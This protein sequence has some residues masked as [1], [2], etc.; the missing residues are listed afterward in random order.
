MSIRYLVR[1]PNPEDLSEIRS[2]VSDLDNLLGAPG[3]DF[4][5]FVT[6]AFDAMRIATYTMTTQ[7]AGTGWKWVS[8]SLELSAEDEKGLAALCQEYG[9]NYPTHL[10]TI[11]R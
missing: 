11:S 7:K 5:R 2:K 6:H 3:E 4:R 10:P 8:A 9:V 1:R